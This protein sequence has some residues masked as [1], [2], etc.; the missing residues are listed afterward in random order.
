MDDPVTR[1]LI[2]YFVVLFLGIS[3]GFFTGWFGRDF[4]AYLDDRKK[5]R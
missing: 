5:N 3:I 2:L 4:C 1:D